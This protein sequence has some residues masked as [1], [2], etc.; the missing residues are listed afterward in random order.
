M[1]ATL[2]ARVADSPLPPL[3]DLQAMAIQTSPMLIEHEATIAAQAARVERAGKE[4]LPDF[5]IAFDYGQRSGFRDLVTATV[6]IPLRR[7][8]RAKQD[9]LLVAARADFAALECR[10]FPDS[11]KP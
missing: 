1:T 9:L 10:Y 4:H 11:P 6:S 2:G 5:D 7:Q 3:A 8:R